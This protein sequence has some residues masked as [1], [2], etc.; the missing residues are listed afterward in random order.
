VNFVSMAGR[1]AQFHQSILESQ[2]SLVDGM[3]LVWLGRAA[4]IPFPER[5]AGSSMLV[6]LAAERS[7]A[8]LRIFFFGGEPGIS[9]LA[10][11]R[12]TEFGPG[13]VAAGF[14][15]PGFGS[16]ESM[17]TPEVIAAINRARPDVLVLSLG[18]KKG[19]QWIARNHVHIEAP[20]ITHLGAA[21]NFIAGSVRRSPVWMQ[22]AGLEWLWRIG[23]EPKLFSRYW[24][25]GIDL[26]TALW[27]RRRAYRPNHKDNTGHVSVDHESTPAGDR[28]SVSGPVTA[29]TVHELEDVLRSRSPDKPVQVVDLAG[30]TE[31]DAAGLGLLYASQFR[32][33]PDQR[34]VL[35]CSTPG[36]MRLL[37][38][39]KAE[40]LLSAGDNRI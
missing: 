2:L 35:T 21:V 36:G 18:A 11:R 32:W 31:L 25:D 30:V 24:N 39:H 22:G 1:D 10:A 8:P 6:R 13:L 20:V 29:R 5:V 14:H 38:T 27:V 9:E 7:A 28:W 34:P 15:S 17:S 3:P 23:Q 33:E 37:R 12:I 19:H 16:I 4:G 40:C 26:V